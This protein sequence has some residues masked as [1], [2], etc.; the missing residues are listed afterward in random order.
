MTESRQKLVSVGALLFS[1]ILVGLVIS[2]ATYSFKPA[3]AALV[4]VAPIAFAWLF[5]AIPTVWQKSQSVV[6]LRNSL[7]LLVIGLYLL[8]NYGFM[9]VRIPLS[10][11]NGIPL[12]ELVLLFSIITINFDTMSTSLSK[13]VFLVPF[14][15]WWTLGIGRSFMDAFE[16]GFWAL[17]DANHV[18][19][20]L[21]LVV[22]FA[23]VTRWQELERFFHWFK[24]ILIISSI[25]A[26]GYPWSETL[27]S[28]SPK[29]VAGAGH[30]VA[31]FF[32]YTNTPTLLL[33]A[34][35]YLIFSAS[36]HSIKE[37]SYAT[38]LLAFTI[39]MFQTRTIYLQ[40]IAI[41]VLLALYRRKSLGKTIVVIVALYGFVAVI[42]M[43]G[44]HF[45]GRIGEVSLPFLLNHF[46]AI[47]GVESEGLEGAARGVPQR[48]EWW[49]DLYQRWTSDASTFLFGMGY[50]F[51]LID[52]EEHSGITV[53][54]PHNSYIS[55]VARLGLS[56][57]VA[58]LWMHILLLRVW[59][60]S[61]M[62][63]RRM[64]W[65]NG[66]KQLLLLMIFFVLLWVHATGEDAFEKPFFA[67]PY[68]FFWGIVLRMN[69]HLRHNFS[70][71][72]I[73]LPAAN[74]VGG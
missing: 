47:G 65:Q 44:L 64:H 67:I 61:Y 51:P 43:F 49:R 3:W 25:Y 74:G 34:A 32:N 35:S 12:G 71:D 42:S 48:V 28:L 2:E 22:G 14:L 10:V 41:F 30:E 58:F 69:W 54:E 29:L 5:F 60:H 50:G 27:Q 1:A 52:F 53:R 6:Q 23:F 57:I 40:V 72:A 39:F 55:V 62:A 56:G 20:S 9:Q 16:Y 36:R 63:C 13:T 68:Y 24:W 66:E 73:S 18:I 11:S 8:L 38:L 4:P 15:A 37:L 17:R 45:Q 7:L 46:L 31:L 26:L 70:Y 21:F 19:E 33:L 59:H